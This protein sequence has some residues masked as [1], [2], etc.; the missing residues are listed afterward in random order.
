MREAEPAPVRGTRLRPGTK[1][2]ELTDPGSTRYP[3][4]ENLGE[5]KA[6]GWTVLIPRTRG[7]IVPEAR[8]VPAGPVLAGATVVT[9]RATVSAR[10]SR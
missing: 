6:S 4:P 7:A 9:V 10:P 2:P 8:T 3:R 5:G 1:K